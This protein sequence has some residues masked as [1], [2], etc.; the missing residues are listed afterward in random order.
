MRREENVRPAMMKGVSMLGDQGSGI[1]DRGSRNSAATDE[2][3]DFDRIPVA[4]DDVREGMPSDNGA[5]VLDGHPPG[6]DLEMCQQLDHRHR[7]LELVGFAVEGDVHRSQSMKPESN[8]R[9]SRG[10]SV[11]WPI[12]VRQG[13]PLNQSG[14]RAR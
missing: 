11:A 1:G 6:V 14:L 5:V 2:I 7:P 9:G 13:K 8:R 12:G 4:D 3:H 10:I